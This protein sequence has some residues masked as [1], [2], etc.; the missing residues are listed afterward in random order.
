M[1]ASEL[2][3]KSVEDLKKELLSLARANFEL[4]I[5][6]AAKQLSKTSEIRKTKKDIARVKTILA[7]KEVQA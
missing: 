3:N 1:K 2:R 5:Q 4:K 7:E 6:L